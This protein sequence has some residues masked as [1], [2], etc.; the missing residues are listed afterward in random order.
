[1]KTRFL[2]VAALLCAVVAA[3][4]QA[5][6]PAKSAPANAATAE[7][8]K[9]E[10]E[11]KR[12]AEPV[13]NYKGGRVTVGEL[14]DSIARQNA[15]MRSR[16]K[17]KA[18]L[19]DLL[20]KTLRLALLSDEAARRG[21][22]KDEVVRQSVKQ[23]SVQLLLKA[24]LDDKL[25]AAS[26]PK[27]DVEKYYDDHIDEY[28]QPAMQRASHVLVATEQEAKTLLAQA[29]TMDLRAFRQL[30]RDKSTDQA[31]KLSGGDLR[32]FDAQGKTRGDSAVAVPPAIA[33][34]AF[35]LKTIGDTA[36]AP[37]KTDAGYS[38]V[39]L[40]GQRPALSRKLSEVEET[41][42]ARL[43]NERKQ[44]ASEQ[45]VQKLR[46]QYKPEIHAELLDA[47]KL[48]EPATPAAPRQ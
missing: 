2:P 45:L 20:D 24:D 38:I 15:F 1:M 46:D 10:A 16:Y 42:R 22:D 19:K 41:I 44:A 6:Q 39:K 13:A 26:I 31:T 40:T 36:K 37:V 21:Y 17:D 3:A 25:S 14:E 43:W 18:S 33:K 23:N 4:A 47:I 29:K 34:A 48:E 30:A 9:S 5:P 35:A 32:Y 12:R 7:Q 28:V 11:Q 27:P 8:P